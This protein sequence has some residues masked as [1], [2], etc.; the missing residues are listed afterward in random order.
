MTKAAD[1]DNAYRIRKLKQNPR[2]LVK[3]VES[4]QQAPGIIS[5]N[6]FRKFQQNQNKKRKETKREEDSNEK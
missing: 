2:R 3:T 1:A 4:L 6:T 5:E